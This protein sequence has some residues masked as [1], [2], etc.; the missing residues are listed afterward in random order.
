MAYQIVNG[1]IVA[2][3][4]DGQTKKFSKQN[5]DIIIAECKRQGIT[6][7]YLI[8]GILATISKESAFKPQSENLNYSADGLKK[9]FPSY[10]LGGLANASEYAKKP[11]KIANYIYGN[12]IKNGKIVPGRVGNSLPG[13]GWKYRGRGFNQI[14]FKGIY[15]DYVKLIPNLIE[16]PDLLNNVPEAAK[17][18]IL[19]YVKNFK[20]PVIKSRY[21]KTAYD[22][23]DWNEA[24]LIVINVTAGLANKPSDTVVKDNYN[25]AKLSHQFLIDYLEK[26]PEGTT[27]PP[28]NPS[29][30]NNQDQENFNNSQQS[31]DQQSDSSNNS[32]SN[33]SND[34]G[35]PITN[36]TQIFP[37]TI[38]PLEISFNTEDFNRRDKKKFEKGLGF[39]PFIYY[40]GVQLDSK[41]IFSFKLY[42]VGM[43]PT[44]DISFRDTYNFFREDGFPADD[45]FITIYLNSRSINLRSI[46]M[47]FKIYDFKDLGESTYIL[48]G[49]CDIPQ[50][51]LRKFNSY[52]NKTSHETLQEVAKQ[53]GI[54]FC[55][56]ISNSDDKMTWVNTGFKNIEFIQNVISN[57]YV[58]DNSFQHCYI[59]FYYNLCYIDIA[60]ELNRD[61]SNDKMIN[62]FGYAL[63]KNEENSDSNDESLIPSV[64]TN[65][66]ALRQTVSFFNNYEIFNKSTKVSLEKA[67]RSRSKFYDSVKKE[68]LVF[69]IESQTSDGSKTL[70]LKGKPNDSTFYRENI[71]TIW[72]G[73]QDFYDEGSGN[74]HRNYNYAVPQ[75]RQNLDDLTKVS[76]KIT[77]PSA[78]YNLYLFQKI[79]VAFSDIKPSPVND[80]KFL[81]RFT[82]DWLITNINF[83]YDGNMVQEVTLVKR[84]LELSPEES[85]N[86]IPKEE[87]KNETSVPESTNELTPS[88][89]SQI[90]EDS[91]QAILPETVPTDLI[92]G[93]TST[94]ST[95]I[96]TASTSVSD[97]ETW[98]AGE[99]VSR[100]SANA[101][102][103]QVKWEVIRAAQPNLFDVF[104]E[105]NGELEYQFSSTDER[106]AKVEA[107]TIANDELTVILK[108]NNINI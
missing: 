51:Y 75:N 19:Y 24:L 97:V 65:D 68:L 79:L 69:D 47:D 23:N 29:N 53:M 33:N 44:L 93:T 48:T 25:K 31:D 96:G 30:V 62:G 85:E 101:F 16:N 83:I 8:A 88:E 87:D 102:G 73:K 38:A 6:N 103:Y 26:N 4:T 76:C 60:K 49:I 40:C 98:R 27:V 58:S 35:I 3:A 70:I 14:T 78:N 39:L 36:L 17:V 63:L 20:S 95:T 77:L 64:L 104:V 92:S 42:H 84:E 57:S 21:G 46:H 81:K 86:T 2:K 105:E 99:R 66:P 55:S 28:T 89:Q 15:Q 52:G 7:K 34:P 45:S 1:N 67:Y 74:V 13:D 94:I 5:V 43:I 12:T 11:E 18:T 82:G 108:N 41:D 71:S 91:N 22:V 72:I 80:Q 59:D 32:D 107:N 9:I 54:G 37:P 56:N 50:L 90:S 61:T 106:D 10:F 100:G